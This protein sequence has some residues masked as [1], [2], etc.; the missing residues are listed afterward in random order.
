MKII[1]HIGA[2]KTGTSSIQGTLMNS[3][4]RLKECGIYYLGLMLEFAPVKMYPWQKAS[5]TKQFLALDNKQAEE[6]VETVLRKTIEVLQ[7]AGIHTIIWSNEWFFGRHGSVLNPMKRL[8][9]SGH[10]ISVI[11]YVRRHDAW[12][13]SAYSQWGIKHKTYPGK[14]I[15]F[16]EYIKKRPVGF[17]G[18]F[19][20]WDQFFG[21]KFILRNF[22]R[23]DDVVDDFSNVFLIE[24]NILIKNR[25]NESPGNEELILRALFNDKRDHDVMP[26][27]FERLFQIVHIDF[28]RDPVDWLNEL[29][30]KSEEL[31]KVQEAT[32]DDQLEVNALLARRG[33]PELSF[34]EKPVKPLEI[35]GN[36]AYSVLF[37]L[38]ERLAIQVNDLRVEIK[39]LKGSSESGGGR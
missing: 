7:G 15:P 24:K 22:D 8:E 38:I 6:Q 27:A 35:N 19:K 25:V 18:A 26:V 10:D 3:A 2:G 4:E 30:P 11:A 29:L 5:A 23:I 32:L 39:N 1:F 31:K 13:R 17:A 21:E 12:A 36:I 34:E 37:Q 16:N 9:Q 20:P 14:I 33:Q 28:K